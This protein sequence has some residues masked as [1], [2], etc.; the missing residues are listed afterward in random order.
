MIAATVLAI[1]LIFGMGG[2]P[3]GEFMSEYAEDAI[4]DTISDK[5]RRQL[6]LNELESL[7]DAIEDFN[8][9]VSKDIKQF[10]ELVENYDS[11]PE[12]FDNMFSSVLAN[13]QQGVDKLW[14]ERSAM[15][16]HITAEEW[17]TIISSAKAKMEEKSK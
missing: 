3:F 5:E 14:D 1:F 7:E 10:H 6:A 12:D 4:E 8:K 9:G 11:T 15:L 17:K 16:T 13:R 2:G